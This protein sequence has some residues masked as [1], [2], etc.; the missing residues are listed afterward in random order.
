MKL[1]KLTCDQLS[2]HPI[3]FNSAGLTLIVGDGATDKLHD[4]SSNGVGKTLLLYLV[5]HCLGANVDP[6]LRKTVPKWN[7]C[8]TIELAGT[9]YNIERLGDGTKVKVD[10]TRIAQT[11]LRDW[12]NEIG[13]FELDSKVPFLSFRSL[14]KR[15]ARYRRED[16]VNPL[17]MNK[18][19]DV[20]ALFR[21]LY[22]LG[23]DCSLAVSKQKNKLVLDEISDAE[24]LTK[25]DVVL[26]EIL[27]AGTQPRL[28]LEWLN[29]EIPRQRAEIDGFQVAENYRHIELEASEL[30]GRL[31]E[32]E[33]SISLLTFQ[34][35]AIEKSLSLHPDITREDLLSL[36]EGL[37]DIFKPEALRHFE[38]VE[39]FRAELVTNRKR[40][41]T[42]E[43]SGLISHRL[44]LDNERKKIA[45]GRDEA[46]NSL[47]GKKALDEYAAVC[48]RLA[49]YEEERKTLEKYLNLAAVFQERKQ[50][51]RERQVD[52]DRLAIEY[53]ASNPIGDADR[54]FK[55]A[56]RIMY[57]SAPSGIVVDNNVNDNQI[58]YNMSVEIEGDDSD[59]INSARI[60]AFDW[61]LLM[62]GAH[63]NVDF[64]WHD[65]RIFADIDPKCRAAWFANLSQVLPRTGKQYI[66]A[67]NTEN[68]DAMRPFLS[69]ET[70][71]GLESAVRL[72]LRGDD[73]SHKLLGIQFG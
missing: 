11:E 5:H 45:Q 68:Y 69:N 19:P 48:A 14:I 26:R 65:N 46:L 12:L 31:R 66:A 59:G 34:E 15:F 57:P 50:A 6:R 16:C 32:I 2:F 53:L 9:K 61:L 4:G 67:L 20:E 58:R 18:E 38:K 17:R 27:R 54:N 25:N 37:G 23:L 8:L 22:L 60:L 70:A 71:A 73:A 28:R 3:E 40:R 29:A 41:L 43:R 62:H 55:K 51:L 42:D 56:A 33:K 21:T 49:G 35:N 47:M 63:H 13:V 24:A 52:E 64:L 72:R 39:T 10:G 7:F 44:Q 36:Y 30:T 1:V